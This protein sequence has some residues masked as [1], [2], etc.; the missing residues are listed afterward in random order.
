VPCPQ[1]LVLSVCD[2]SSAGDTAEASRVASFGNIFLL[3]FPGPL[4]K[5]CL[6]LVFFSLC[7]FSFSAFLRFFISLGVPFVISL[8][9]TPSIVKARPLSKLQQA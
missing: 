4:L 2:P 7:L 8:Y 6:H 5:C 1:A 3:R 9:T